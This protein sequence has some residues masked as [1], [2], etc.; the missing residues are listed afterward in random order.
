MV[1]LYV[2]LELDYLPSSSAVEFRSCG[3]FILLLISYILHPVT[4]WLYSDRRE[5]AVSPINELKDS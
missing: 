5:H 2:K 1:Q 3:S 4:T